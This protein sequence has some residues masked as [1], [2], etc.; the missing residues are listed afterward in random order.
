MSSHV[1]PR[2]LALQLRSFLVSLSSLSSCCR[3]SVR[4]YTYPRFL[5]HFYQ[6]IFSFLFARYNTFL[7]FVVTYT[8]ACRLSLRFNS[9]MSQSPTIITRLSRVEASLEERLVTYCGVC[10]AQNSYRHYSRRTSKIWSSDRCPC[11]YL[12]LH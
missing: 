12:S 1:S 2:F 6:F 4:S 3:V 8:S 7:N 10:L 5:Q 11:I 9:V